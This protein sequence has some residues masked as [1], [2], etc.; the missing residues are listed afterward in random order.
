MKKNVVQ[1]LLKKSMAGALAAAM[2][3]S[4]VSLL[5]ADTSVAAA[6]STQYVKTFNIQDYQDAVAP[7]ATDATH[8][9]WVFAGWYEDEACNNPIVEKPTT[10]N[11]YAK[12][13]PAEVL[14]VKCQMLEGTTAEQEESKLRL[15][16][17]VDTLNYDNV[18]FEIKV[19][20]NEAFT[21][22]TSTVL[23]EITAEANGVDFEYA[24]SDLCEAANYF[25]TVTLT[26]IPSSGYA[27]GIYITPYWE[28]LDGT[29]VYGVSRFARVE[30]GYLNIVN[31]PVR[32]CGDK[33]V[34]AGLVQVDYDEANFKFYGIDNGDVFE[35]MDNV[36]T[37]SVVRCMGYVAEELTMNATA[38]GMFVHLRF[39]LTGEMPQDDVTF[40]VTQE[41][42]CNASEENVSIDIAD[43][44][45]KVL[46]AQND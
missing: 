24:P 3:L 2:V 30:D 42:F 22:K 7:R 26:D 17:T 16:S 46:N 28:T 15:V 34:A 11:C 44:V 12:F 40:T 37:G 41:D 1:V 31:V 27:T 43:V 14:S 29:K 36:D 19:G 38:D 21:Y 13:V 32:V 23:R 39:Q 10:G 5:T 4:G 45:Y 8:S 6:D 25:T 33:S 9:N 35:N 20:N 18:G